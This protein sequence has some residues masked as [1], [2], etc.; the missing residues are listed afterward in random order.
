MQF[1]HSRM[2][3]IFP[4]SFNFFSFMISAFYVHNDDF[5]YYVRTA[6]YFLITVSHFLCEKKSHVLQYF[7]K[8]FRR[9]TDMRPEIT[10]LN[11]TWWLFFCSWR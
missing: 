6:L 4:K 11:D 5:Y 2:V 9:N 1:D 10:S 3:I 8:S 7:Y